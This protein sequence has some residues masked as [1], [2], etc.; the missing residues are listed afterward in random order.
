MF[1]LYSIFG[2][3]HNFVKLVFFS[4]EEEAK[5]VPRC[6]NYNKNDK[7]DKKIAQNFSFQGESKLKK[8]S[9]AAPLRQ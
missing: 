7:K 6:P 5:E 1:A 9:I 3:L 8:T 4:G 2:I